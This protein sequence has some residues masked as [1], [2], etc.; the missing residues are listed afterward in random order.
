[1]IK[2]S[3]S[4]SVNVCFVPAFIGYLQTQLQNH[5]FFVKLVGTN[6]KLLN[7]STPGWKLCIVVVFLQ[8]QW[9]KKLKQT[10]PKFELLNP[11]LK[12][13]YFLF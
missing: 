3:V 7:E 8:I 1:M 2:L 6:L 12:L 5:V 9:N 10:Q 11:L 4:T 13:N